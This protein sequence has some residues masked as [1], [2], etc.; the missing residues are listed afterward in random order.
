MA[1]DK[2]AIESAIRSAVAFASG[3]ALTKIIIARPDAP[4]PAKPYCTVDLQTTVT[5]FT[6]D[7]SA[8]RSA[9]FTLT[10]RT[11]ANGFVHQ[12][13]I[14]DT[15]F[16]HTATGASTPTTV[17]AALVALVNASAIAV[18]AA[19]IAGAQYSLT[20]DDLDIMLFVLAD[21]R[22]SIDSGDGTDSTMENQI[23]VA[24]QFYGNDSYELATATKHRI[25][26][27]TAHDAL[28]VGGVRFFR[29]L[30]VLNAPE[31][32]EETW[33][34]RHVLDLYV[35]VVS[36]ELD[37]TGTIESVDGIGTVTPDG[38]AQVT[39]PIDVSALD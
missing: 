38:G 4:R 15:L 23:T 11:T 19:V 12:L 39:I 14:G 33:E 7:E 20:S 32:T 24:L 9:V 8:H 36:A 16:T 1:L 5:P 18:T 17:A 22:Q 31:L 10:V 28:E 2:D 29:A 37:N 6:A 35:A 30:D 34:E 21:E 25:R 3:L 13:K 27:Q 26:L